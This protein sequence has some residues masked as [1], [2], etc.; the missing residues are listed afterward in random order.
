MFILFITPKLIKS[1]EKNNLDDKFVVGQCSDMHGMKGVKK[2]IKWR[3]TKKENN[4]DGRRERRPVNCGVSNGVKTKNDEKEEQDEKRKT[5]KQNET[6]EHSPVFR[7]EEKKE[8]KKERKEK[9]K[10]KNMKVVLTQ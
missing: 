5:E 1:A 9:K 3:T 6:T 10:T 2:R 7:N 8:E 4:D